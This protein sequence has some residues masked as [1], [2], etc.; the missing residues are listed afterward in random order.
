MPIE[1]KNR[2]PLDKTTLFTLEGCPSCS[3]IEKLFDADI[4]EGKIQIKHCD[5]DGSEEE[6]QNCYQAVL[7]DHFDGFPL[8][9]SKNGEKL[10]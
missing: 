3:D 5:M 9:I 4:K 8:L 7:Q 1:T 2:L 6:Q 10:F